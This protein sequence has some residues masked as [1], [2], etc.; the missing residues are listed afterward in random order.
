MVTRQSQTSRTHRLEWHLDQGSENQESMTEES[1]TEESMTEES[2]TEDS[3]TEESTAQESTAQEQDFGREPSCSPCLSRY[4]LSS[5]YQEESCGASPSRERAVQHHSAQHHAARLSIG[6]EVLR[7][8]SASTSMQ[9][10]RDGAVGA[11]R[12]EA[13]VSDDGHVA[14]HRPPA[15]QR[16]E[17]RSQPRSRRRIAAATMVRIALEQQENLRGSDA[18]ARASS[19]FPSS[20]LPAWAPE[21]FRAPEAVPSLA[22][23]AQ[24]I[25]C[26]QAKPASSWPTHVPRV[27]L[28]CPDIDALLGGGLA[29]GAIHELIGVRGSEPGG[30]LRRS[31]SGWL[32]PFACIIS[33]V[34]LAL[35]AFDA[36]PNAES[37]TCV[38]WIGERIHPNPDSFAHLPTILRRGTKD[39]GR[40][41]GRDHFANGCG[42][43]PD[44]AGD[45]GLTLLQRSLF[46]RDT[47]PQRSG[48]V[49]VAR[50]AVFAE[51]EHIHRESSRS[52]QNSGHVSSVRA[53]G[54]SAPSPSAAAES[55]AWCAEQAIHLGA[56]A[57]IVLDANGLCPRSW[58]RL[59]LAAA[60]SPH[61]PIVLAVSAPCSGDRWD[62]GRFHPT[63]TRWSVEPASDGPMGGSCEIP[64]GLRSVEACSDRPVDCIGKDPRPTLLEPTRLEPTRLDPRWKVV[65]R[66]IRAASRDVAASGEG[67][68]P[69][70]S[71]LVGLLESGAMALHVALPRTSEGFGAWNHLEQRVLSAAV[72]AHAGWHRST[73]TSEVAAS[74]AN[75]AIGH[76]GVA[77]EAQRRAM[78]GTPASQIHAA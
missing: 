77:E 27:S 46:V 19:A 49:Q 16:F 39:G 4:G 59:Q 14:L 74:W 1:M 60:S 11:V 6:R 30:A 28:G 21:D 22:N 78:P 70:A 38:A 12:D 71:E 75:D 26:M 10:Q 53:R 15:T 20:V 52:P 31:G 66:S 32:P 54:A 47:A 36:D 55:R 41:G 67:I 50:R 76:E 9:E 48:R 73:S 42:V 62:S 25:S 24:A 40:D 37:G 3:T 69:R 57:I 51:A 33:M 63:A 8:T 61:M 34:H 7:A 5:E 58:R 45:H 68:G 2:M 65:L 44:A 35:E 56:A 43:L 23:G 18:G 64:C 13:D 72:R 17:P 29:R